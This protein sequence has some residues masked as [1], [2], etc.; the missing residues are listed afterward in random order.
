MARAKKSPLSITKKAQEFLCTV[1]VTKKIPV[2]HRL[3]VRS[4]VNEMIGILGFDMSFDDKKV[5]GDMVY[6]VNGIELIL[7][8][9]TAYHLVGSI[10]DLD[11]KGELSFKHLDIID[12][13]QGAEN[14][15][16]N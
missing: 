10:L 8:R 15:V 9:D 3:R 7:D 6:K 1:K 14:I 5:D 13:F 12:N 2:K 4:H 11:K 16:Y